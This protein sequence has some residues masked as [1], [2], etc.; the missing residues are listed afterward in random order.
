MES[1]ISVLMFNYEQGSVQSITKKDINHAKVVYYGTEHNAK[2][3]E[4]IVKSNRFMKVC[5]LVQSI[6]CCLMS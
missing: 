3:M 1:D 6:C 4:S 5:I 2:V